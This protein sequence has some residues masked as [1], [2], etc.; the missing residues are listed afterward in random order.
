MNTCWHQ[1]WPEVG[2]HFKRL[3][4]TENEVKE[5][6]KITKAICSDRF[7]NMEERIKELIEN[8]YWEMANEEL[9]DLIIP[10]DGESNDSEEDKESLNLKLTVNHDLP[11]FKD[12]RLTSNH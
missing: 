1:W 2:N 5:I 7:S 12:L 6:L 3:L 11:L 8:D 9:D 10:A 4:L